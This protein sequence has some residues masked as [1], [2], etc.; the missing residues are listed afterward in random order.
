MK[1][2]SSSKSQSG[3]AK[4]NDAKA[5][6]SKPKE[7]EVNDP[8]QTNSDFFYGDDF[9][10]FPSTSA[11]KSKSIKS[12]RTHVERLDESLS[13]Y[14]DQKTLDKISNLSLNNS[15]KYYTTYFKNIIQAFTQNDEAISHLEKEVSTTHS[16]SDRIKEITAILKQIEEENRKLCEKEASLNLC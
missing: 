9:L 11:Q 2:K 3:R 14:A 5:D 10:F 8:Q 16:A 4:S 15:T 6:L 7:P 1:C 13:K 12:S